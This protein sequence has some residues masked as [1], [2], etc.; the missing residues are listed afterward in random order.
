MGGLEGTE[1]HAEGLGPGFQFSCHS[2]PAVWSWPGG[3][4]LLSLGFL[5]CKRWV[6]NRSQVS[7]KVQGLVLAYAWCPATVGQWGCCPQPSGLESRD[8]QAA[9]A[10]ERAGPGEVGG[11]GQAP[12]PCCLGLVAK[13]RVSQEW[14]GSG[15]HVG[16]P[17]FCP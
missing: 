9:A 15:S 11:K 1:R 13:A 2:L 3:V 14:P 17:G 8:S 4:T 6:V 5:V 7:V 16:P 10:W 12:G